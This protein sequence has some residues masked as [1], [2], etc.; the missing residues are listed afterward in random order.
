L[1]HW[2]EGVAALHTEVV[3]FQVDVEIRQDQLILDK[4]PHDADHLVAV[5]FD[6]GVRDLIFAIAVTLACTGRFSE[7]PDHKG[8]RAH[9]QADRGRRWVARPVVALCSAAHR[10]ACY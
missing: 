9:W 5:E 2:R 3:I 10:K 4:A 8:R 7:G 6:D 1:S